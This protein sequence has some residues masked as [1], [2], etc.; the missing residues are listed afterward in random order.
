[1]Q[2]EEQANGQGEDDPGMQSQFHVYFVLLCVVFETTYCTW[3]RDASS[4]G[5]PTPLSPAMIAILPCRCHCPPPDQVREGDDS[6]ISVNVID[7]GYGQM[8]G[9]ADRGGAWVL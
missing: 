9:G 3:R 8:T 7:G 1:M 5:M 6:R 4:S 2:S